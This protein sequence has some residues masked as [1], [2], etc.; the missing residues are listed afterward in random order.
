MMET[1]EEAET[2]ERKK[3]MNRNI[4]E[5][6]QIE[7]SAPIPETL[8]SPLWKK[9]EIKRLEKKIIDQCGFGWLSAIWL[10]G[11]RRSK[12]EGS[13]DAKVIGNRKKAGVFKGPCSNV[14]Y[15]FFK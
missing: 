12:K 8:K 11:Q 2:K 13:P 5:K 10:T 9:R 4:I 1:L 14:R 15:E 6:Y 3:E 7:M